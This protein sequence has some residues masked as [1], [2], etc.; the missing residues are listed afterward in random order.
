MN[1]LV[2]QSRSLMLRLMGGIMIK[3]ILW[4]ACEGTSLW[5]TGHGGCCRIIWAC[6]QEATLVVNV[7]QT[8]ALVDREAVRIRS[9]DKHQCLN[10][11]LDVRKSTRKS[12]LRFIFACFFFFWGMSYGCLRGK[13]VHHSEASKEQSQVHFIQVPETCTSSNKGRVLSD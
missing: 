1:V 5:V 4:M 2:C 11:T 8:E 9:M 3:W 7:Y 13:D 12:I 6:F 10:S